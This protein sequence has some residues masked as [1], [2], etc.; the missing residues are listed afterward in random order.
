MTPLPA[1][2]Y[3]KS[4]AFQREP[5]HCDVDHCFGRRDKKLEKVESY[6]NEERFFPA[7]A[8]QIAN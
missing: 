3:S 6:A 1:T 4:H 2:R 5:I 8:N 7:A